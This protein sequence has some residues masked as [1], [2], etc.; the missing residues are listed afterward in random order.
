MAVL[1]GRAGSAP[2]ARRRPFPER[3]RARE[4]GLRLQPSDHWQPRVT[5]NGAVALGLRQGRDG[6]D[7]RRDRAERAKVTFDTRQRERGQIRQRRAAE[8]MVPKAGKES[9]SPPT[10]S[11]TGVAD[12][13]HGR[14]EAVAVCYGDLVGSAAMIVGSV[15]R[16]I[17]P[18][19]GTL[20]WPS[21]VASSGFCT[22]CVPGA[23][24]RLSARV[25]DLLDQV[26]TECARRPESGQRTGREVSQRWRSG[27]RLR[28]E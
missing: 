13:A 1:A 20:S 2:P 15:G 10:F 12:G 7:G 19:S 22:D 25:S 11:T 23:V 18:L 24:A 5:G 14:R 21:R 4:A 8:L 16:S 6:A 9:L 3:R 17:A 27:R 26:S 28:S